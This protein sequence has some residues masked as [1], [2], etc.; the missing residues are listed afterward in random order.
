MEKIIRKRF[1]E[2]EKYNWFWKEKMLPL[3]KEEL[4]S[5]QDGRNYWIFGKRILKKL[6]KNRNCWKVRDHCHYAG[7]YRGAAHSTCNLKFNVPE[8]IPAAFHNGPNY[9]YHFIIN[10][11]ANDFE[12]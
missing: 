1:V 3:T 5:N 11:L 2:P 9:D 4:K 8:E 12:G 6:A 10:T 7:K